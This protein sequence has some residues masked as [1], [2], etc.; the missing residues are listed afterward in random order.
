MT[1]GGYARLTNIIMDIAQ[2]TC[3]GKIIIA[4]E[5]GYDLDGLAASTEAVLKELRGNSTIESTQYEK[6]EGNGYE[7]IRGKL[8]EIKGYQKR[9]WKNL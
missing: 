8:D 6:D 4:L 7:R 3:D 1:E 2:K 9:Y 5:G